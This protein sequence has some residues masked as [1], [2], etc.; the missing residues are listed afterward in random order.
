MV[1]NKCVPYWPDSNGSKEV[2]QYVVT[3]KSER[4]A[5]DYKVRVLEMFPVQQVTFQNPR[6]SRSFLKFV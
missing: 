6:H 3:S 2:G 1:Q 5:A 4:E